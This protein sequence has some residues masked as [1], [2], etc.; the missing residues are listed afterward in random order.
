MQT[1]SWFRDGV[2]KTNDDLLPN[3]TALVAISKGMQ[4]VKHW[5]ESFSS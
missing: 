3:L 1:V 5:T 2:C 4:A